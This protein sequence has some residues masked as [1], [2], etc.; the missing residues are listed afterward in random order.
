MGKEVNCAI[1]VTTTPNRT[2]VFAEWYRHYLEFCKGIPLYIHTD[3][4]YKGVAYSKNKCIA[5][6]YDAGVEHLFLFDDDLFIKS[7]VFLERYANSG[8]NHACWNYDKKVI[9]FGI[10]AIAS[11]PKYSPILKEYVV[12]DKPNGC[13]LYV[14]RGIIDIVGGFDTDFIGY[15]YDHPNWSDRI[16][17]NGMMPA[18]YIDIPNSSEL[19]QM[20]DCESSFSYETRASTIPLNAELYQSKIN[21]KDFKPYK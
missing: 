6:L 12:L 14:R 9:E 7:G 20:A 11:P 15:G 19:F 17:N 21:S 16:Y 10:Q 5:A 8:L 13:M 2:E 18:R 3:Y 1:A 4:E